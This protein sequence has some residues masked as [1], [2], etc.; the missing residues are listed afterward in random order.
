MSDEAFGCD[1]N[2][3]TMSMP[4]EPLVRFPTPADTSVV[5]SL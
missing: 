1:E 3:S 4:L 2:Q 5:C